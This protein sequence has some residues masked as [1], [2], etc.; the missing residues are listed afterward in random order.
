M[1]ATAQRTETSFDRLAMGVGESGQA[2]LG[3]MQ[4]A[5]QGTVANADLM[6]AAN[7]ALVLGLADSAEE[8]AAVTQKLISQAQAARQAIAAVQNSQAAGVRSSHRM[9]L[10]S[11]T[12]PG[13]AAPANI[14]PAPRQR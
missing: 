5:S 8:M 10:Q 14:P 2:M 1:G 6:M 9:T 12:T 11:R 3:A 4:S 13:C 7:R